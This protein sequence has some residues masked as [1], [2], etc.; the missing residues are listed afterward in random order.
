FLRQRLPGGQADVEPDGVGELGRAHR[1]AEVFHRA[2]ERL[3]LH[4]LVEHA[5]RVVHVR[6]EHAVDEKSRR[7]LYRQ[8]QLVDLTNESRGFFYQLGICL[9]GRD[10][11]DQLQLRNRV[12]KVDTDQPRRI[13]QRGGDVGELEARGVGGEDRAGLRRRLE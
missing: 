12:E 8:R 6:P 3:W 11:L 7:V 1:H 10:D 9:L 2:V 13:L 4:A 5:E